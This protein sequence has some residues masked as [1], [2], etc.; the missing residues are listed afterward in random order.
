MGNKKIIQLEIES[1]NIHIKPYSVMDNKSWVNNPMVE[2]GGYWRKIK[3]PKFIESKLSLDATFICRND[4][5]VGDL[6]NFSGVLY[7]AIEKH[8][9]VNEV[10]LVDNFEYPNNG[11]YMGNA[12]NQG[13]GTPS[14]K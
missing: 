12:F 10:V 2:F 8:K 3:H 9:I 14:N 1:V 11:V 13:T 5:H 4:F 7:I 6:Y